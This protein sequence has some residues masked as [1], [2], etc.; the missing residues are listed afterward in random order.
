MFS[1]IFLHMRIALEKIIV[2]FDEFLP[3]RKG[4]P[5]LGSRFGNNHGCWGTSCTRIYI[6][7]P[8]SSIE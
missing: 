3:E 2:L 5:T 6:F 4:W 1:P 7:P 8:S